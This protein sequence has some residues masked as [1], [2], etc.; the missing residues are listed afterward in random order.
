MEKE[1]LERANQGKRARYVVRLVRA[2]GESI[3]KESR[4]S[5]DSHHMW[6]EEALFLVS[7]TV[8]GASKICSISRRHPC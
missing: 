2:W 4:L 8:K 6:A 1:I 3:R 5:V 7:G